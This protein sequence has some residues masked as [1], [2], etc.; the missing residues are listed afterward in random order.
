MMN[1]KK[2]GEYLKNLRLNKKRK[3]GKSYTQY[4]LVKDF[5]DFGV[6]ISINAIGEWESGASLPNPDNLEILAEIFNKTID[7]ILDA[8]DRKEIN[9]EEIYFLVNNN[10]M[11]K[12]DSNNLYQM[13]NEQIKLIVS[14]F[15]ELLYIR[16]YRDFTH[17]EEEEF[18]FLFSHFYIL[19]DYA[20]ENVSKNVNDDYLILKTAICELLF[21][22]RNMNKDEKYW[23]LQKLYSES[24]ELWF[25]FW[26][27]VCDLYQVPIL[28]ERFQSL[29][30]WQ[31]DMLL[32]MFQNIEPYAPNPEKYGSQ[33]LKRYEE[34][35]G[36]FDIN[37]I[38]RNQIKELIKYGACL[39]KCF[40]NVKQGYYEDKRV[41]DRLEELYE[42][43]LKPI[44]IHMSSNDGKVKVYKIENN[45][46]NRFINKYY[47]SLYYQLNG[48]HN[49]ESP[50]ATLEDVYNW[51]INNDEISDD[52]YIKVA[53]N[54][55][56][57]TNKEKKYW[58]A[59]VKSR[60]KINEIFNEFKEKEKSI[61]EGLK[62]IEELKAKLEVGE[63]TY[64]IHKYKLI[65]GNDEKSIREYIEY[66]KEQMTYSEYLKGRDQKTTEELLK[67]IDKLSFDEIKNQ[68]FGIEV[69]EDE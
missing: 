27:D 43:C 60:T 45:Q 65:G 48:Y 52:V 14:R 17:N 36:E 12:N 44:E 59:D 9:Y 40:F 57:D 19:S 47:F 61:A 24:E 1:K 68:Y 66:W 37:E 4:D 56:I 58:L 46:K 69:V 31:K 13:R 3:N 53:Q 20:K 38:R 30:D 21:E 16:I 49:L 22:I 39:N 51:F 15:K 7:E 67:E 55:N 26:R 29:E 23:E 18:R 63:F 6:E 8:E 5:S 41:I 54:H 33:E 32:A 35:N 25:S 34:Y 50:Y 42:L 10:W 2:I 28:Q 11:A 62:E 64:R